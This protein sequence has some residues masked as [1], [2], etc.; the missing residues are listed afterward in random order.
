MGTSSPAP[1]SE[2]TPDGRPLRILHAVSPASVGGL[3]R[4]V[5]ALAR[6]HQRR[7]HD[8]HVAAM[9]GRGDPGTLFL[10]PL[11]E[12]GVSVHLLEVSLASILEERRFVHAL[13]RAHEPDVVHTHG[14]RPDIL[15]GPVARRLGIPTLSTEH[16]MSKMGGRTA[17]Y[18]WLQ[19]RSFR[20]YAA[21]AAVS[22]PIAGTLARNGVA[23][24]RIHTIPNAWS[25]DMRFA[26]R[27]DARRILDIDADASCIGFIGRL[28]GAKGADVLLDAL[29]RLPATVTVAVIGDGPERTSLEAQARRLG[30]HDR[31]RF[32]GEV[33]DAARFLRA[34]D[35]FALPSR[36]EGTPIV[37]FEAMAAGAP[38]VVARVGGVPDM[39]GPDE[40]LSFESED[41]PALGEAIAS[42]LADP[43]AARERARRAEA[44]LETRYGIEPWLDAYES[45]YRSLMDPPAA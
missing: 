27:A 5:H 29:A 18:E 15:D 43:G 13:C 31:V 21:V 36:T 9:L 44:R 37:V 11:R 30:L 40:S 1:R 23:R 3:E 25:G 28:I 24:D 6:G 16:G 32:L 41:A 4:V 2:P 8:V 42:I 7:G 12:A 45:L 26:E 14:Y 20:H 22:D 10:G 19:M 35:A 17:I 33:P 39:V 34:F 38:L